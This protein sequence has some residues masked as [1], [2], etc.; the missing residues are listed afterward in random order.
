[1]QPKAGVMIECI[2]PEGAAASA[3]LGKG[4]I[5]LSING[6]P[7]RDVIDLLFYKNEETLDIVCRQKD[8]THSIRVL[9]G[10]HADLGITVK[11]FR[12]KVCRNQCVFCFVKQLPRGLR[13]SLYVKDED[14]RLSFLYGNYITLSNLEE[15]DRRRIIAQ[16][17][18][19]LYL[20]VHTTNRTLRS[21]MLGN[22]KIPDIMKELK[23]FSDNKIRMHVQIVL[24]PGY[25][26]GRELQNTL[27]DLYK[28]YP[29]TASV[30]V[31]PV[32]LTSYR[33][34]PLTPV[35]KETAVQTIEIINAFQKRN[36]KKHGDPIVYCADEMYLTAEV[37][38]PPL[39]DYGSLPQI[40]N[41]VGMVPLFLS[42]ARKIRMP[43]K[44]S[45]KR[46]VLAITG[47]SF[48]P[49]LNKFLDRLAKKEGI[50]INAIPVE[51]RFFGPSVT[52]TGLLTGR[53]IVSALHDLRD[54]YDTLIVPDTVLKEEEDVLL[55]N[56]TLKDI[57]DATGLEVV[58]AEAT[59][60]GLVNTL[61]SLS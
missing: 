35:T 19:P 41:G 18:S 42:Q 4:D 46:R 16:R 24:C 26:D 8:G 44:V 57:A 23:F 2:D 15:S 51:N 25:N 9:Q 6:K 39:K 58:K 54:E 11:P 52:V 55:D 56:V 40:E 34:V 48:Y 45:R 43:Q 38:F 53:D 47:M 20:S 13:K 61:A 37:P 36:M 22:A 3:G 27:R 33:K 10:E 17:L 14:Y 32:G 7:L 49:F 50:A 29:Y 5:L 59:P 21:K 31:V 28:F 1:M 30:A 60:R 12:V